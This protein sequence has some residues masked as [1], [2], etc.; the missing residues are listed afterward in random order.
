MSVSESDLLMFRKLV[1][2]GKRV[3]FRK[4][5]IAL[6]LGLPNETGF[7]H[8][9]RSITPIRPSTRAPARS[10]PA[11]SSPTPAR[12]RRSTRASSAGSACLSTTTPDALLVPQRS[13]AYDQGGWYLLV[14]GSG[15][16]VE[17]RYVTPGADRGI[18]QGDRRE[19]EAGRPGD[20]PGPAAGP[21]G[22][23]GQTP[24]PGD[25]RG[26]RGDR[27][28]PLDR[29]ATGHPGKAGSGPPEKPASANPK[30]PGT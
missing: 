5:T 1:R 27:L 6:D 21:A 28:A 30:G 20:R 13:L 4:E 24:A 26:E 16:K 8:R 23:R 11:G 7:P 29:E 25:N 15:N 22:D 2:E 18:A 9:A 10:R 14:V 19:L 12:I 17:Q 3:D